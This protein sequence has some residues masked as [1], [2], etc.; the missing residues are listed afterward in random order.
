MASP[1]YFKINPDVVTSAAFYDK[2]APVKMLLETEGRWIS[3]KCPWTETQHEMGHWVEHK[4]YV[5]PW[6]KIV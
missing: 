1:T 5:T 6:E 3:C 4:R 2:L